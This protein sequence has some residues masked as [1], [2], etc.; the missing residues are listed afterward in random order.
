MHIL[1]LY[2]CA[3]LFNRTHDLHFPQNSWKNVNIAPP[4]KVYSQ[5]L[6]Q[7]HLSK[8]VYCAQNFIRFHTIE[9]EIDL[10]QEFW[11]KRKSSSPDWVI[12]TQ[13]ASLLF[14]IVYILHVNFC[15]IYPLETENFGKSEITALPPVVRFSPKVDKQ[16]FKFG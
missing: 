6:H 11:G 9:S 15:P 8:W 12:C 10:S 1:Y 7:Y 4:N 16:Q 3:I 14:L 13:I 2:F 5:K